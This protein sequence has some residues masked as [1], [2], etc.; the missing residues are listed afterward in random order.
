MSQPTNRWKL[1]LFVVIGIAALLVTV[2]WLGARTLQR[3][4]T[5]LYVY[6]DQEVTGLDVG[7]PL[8]FRGIKIGKVGVIRA[9]PDR[10]HVEVIIDVF[11]D[12]LR[13]LGF[14]GPED[15]EGAGSGGEPPDDLRVQLVA[16]VITGVAALESDYVDVEEFP[17]PE[18]PFPVPPNTLHAIPSALMRLEDSLMESISRLPALLD[19]GTATLERLDRTLIELDSPRLSESAN[20]LLA[21]LEDQAEKIY[22]LPFLQQGGLSFT[23]LRAALQELRGFVEDLRA[24][25]GTFHQLL[26][27]YE[28]L[29]DRIDQV[30]VDSDLPGT[31]EDLRDT[32]G[33]FRS[34]GASIDAL[35]RDARGELTELRAT[36]AAARRLF[37]LLER[38]PAALLRGR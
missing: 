28:G 38:D 21:T 34:A 29:G 12:S 17:E 24:Q 8:L 35:G 22:E 20:S 3:E 31:L 37:A 13:D 11:L 7:A 5:Q 4:T 30:L 26:E 19:Q 6:F 33:S 1:G 32:S 9:A 10:R 36:L 23:E 14:L 27:R 16:S 18:Y 25:D 2:A 15:L